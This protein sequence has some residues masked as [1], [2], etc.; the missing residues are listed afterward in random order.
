MH[1]V[2]ITLP[3]R[4]RVDYRNLDILHDALV[5]AWTAAGAPA[6][7][8][9]G[10]AAG[11]WHF[12]ALG[13]RRNGGN[14][15]HTL[16]VG[17]PDPGLEK[18]LTALDPA[19]VS[20]ARA[21]TGEAVDF[22]TADVVPDPDPVVPGMAS[23]G[24]VMLSPLVVS[25]KEKG[26]RRWANH[27]D[28]VD[29]TAAVNA[30]LTRLADRPVRLKVAPDRLYVRCNPKHD[31]LIPLKQF[32]DG[33]KSFVIGMRIPLVLQ[34]S[35]DDLR[36]AWHSGIGEKNRFGFGCVGLAEKGVGR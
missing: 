18:W 1:R 16:V 35:E 24:V 14:Q 15:V 6:D 31:A 3:K 27:V 12:A 36:L 4:N 7:A 32:P 8:V 30:R 11:F 26:K 22:S 2:R 20:H 33:R 23:L 21:A 5:N 10:P 28:D 25:R 34:G 19:H 29:L 17:T 9:V 13:W